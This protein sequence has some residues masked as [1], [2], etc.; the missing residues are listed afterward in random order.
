[1]P[2]TGD[3]PHRRG[4]HREHAGVLRE[5]AREHWERVGEDRKH[6]GIVGEQVGLGN[7]WPSTDPYD[8]GISRTDL[9]DSAAPENVQENPMGYDR[10]PVFH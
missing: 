4:E 10:E 7:V 8:A 3:I 9:S 5:Q 2:R 6:S 1:M